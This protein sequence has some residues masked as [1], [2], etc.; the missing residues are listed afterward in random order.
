MI[1]AKLENACRYPPNYRHYENY[2]S[3]S[4]V[5]RDAT[6]QDYMEIMNKQVEFAD[7]LAIMIDHV[8]YCLRT[9]EGKLKYIK[10]LE[11]RFGQMSV[12]L[13]KISYH[14]ID[15]MDPGQREKLIN[16]QPELVA[17]HQAS[18]NFNLFFKSEFFVKEARAEYA[19]RVQAFALNKEV[20][21]LVECL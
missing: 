13:K 14:D 11:R 12:D 16:E 5:H 10:Y 4:F 9:P 1:R 20:Y 19:K 7:F 21:S 8:K 3:Y 18:H 17:Y 6:V 2:N 15:E